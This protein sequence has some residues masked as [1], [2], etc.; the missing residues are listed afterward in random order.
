MCVGGGGGGGGGDEE[1]V[2]PFSHTIETSS[3][4]ATCLD[5]SQEIIDTLESS[6]QQLEMEG[7]L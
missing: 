2:S 3:K 7:L 4:K 1:G 5:C 6:D